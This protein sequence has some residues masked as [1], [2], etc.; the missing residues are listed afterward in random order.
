MLNRAITI[1]LL[2][3]LVFCAYASVLVVQQSD[4]DMGIACL[5]V[6]S[7][8]AKVSLDS[9]PSVPEPVFI[10]TALSQSEPIP[11]AH[12]PSLMK[13]YIPVA[14]KPPTA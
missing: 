5:D 12:G 3:S 4:G 9:A 7:S 14:E 1:L 6:C 2:A 13:I 8:I 10:F 11:A